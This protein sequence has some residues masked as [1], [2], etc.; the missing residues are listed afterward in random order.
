MHEWAM[1]MGLSPA[2]VR[3]PQ[4]PL[5]LS[6]QEIG[7]VI[8]SV[9]LRCTH[10][11]AY[12]FFTDAARTRQLPLTRDGQVDNEQPGCVHAGM[13]LYRY[14]Y[15]G[16]PFV[17]S[18]L[19]ADCFAHAREARELDMAASP[20][21]LA[22]WGVVAIEME[23]PEGRRHYVR[24]QEELA[25]VAQQLRHR[26][27]ASLDNVLGATSA[28]SAPRGFEAAESDPNPALGRFTTVGD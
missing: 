27:V 20:Y 3:H 28:T 2:Q 14:A 22:E 10:F 26:V 21:D 5:R 13:D 1:V 16:L 6:P 18:D 7:E 11:D 19:V 25:A 4:V 8:D 24:R 9:G 12:R 17:S 23:T 15:E